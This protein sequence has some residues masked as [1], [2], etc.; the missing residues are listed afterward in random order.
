MKV[1]AISQNGDPAELEGL[2]PAA[3]RRGRPPRLSAD[4]VVQAAL[5]L[6]NT[7]PS[8]EFTM[9][10]VAQAVATTTMALYRYFPSREALL[11]AV[12]RH[13]FGQFSMPAP[14]PS[15]AW[16]DTLFAWQCA[17][18]AHFE[19]YPAL[20][21]LMAWNGR[22]SGAWMRVQMPVIEALH[23]AGF[24]GP[25]LAHA[26]N[27]FLTD[28]SGMLTIELSDLLLSFDG[29]GS[30]ASRHAISVEDSLDLLDERQKALILGLVPY[31]RE[32][33]PERVLMTGFRHLIKGI[34]LLL[35]EAPPSPDKHN[36]HPGEGR[37]PSIGGRAR[38]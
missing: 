29:R 28:T 18:K 5:T 32:L 16:Q 4:M 13:V 1:E 3:K 24:R 22:V 20:T 17:L 30:A 35:E 21:R 11:E 8:A 14:A 15:A 37:D 19:R 34:E 31:A 25:L 2:E 7:A 9:T 12:S 27:W 6:L 33:D 26:V 36:R 10:Q 38:G 23:D